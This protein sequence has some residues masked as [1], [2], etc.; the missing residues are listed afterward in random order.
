MQSTSAFAV[1]FVV[2]LNFEL[3]SA[4]GQLHAVG[5]VFAYMRPNCSPA[6]TCG[7]H[8]CLAAAP[9]D[10]DSVL[11]QDVHERMVRPGARNDWAGTPGM[12]LCRSR[13]T[14]AAAV[15]QALCVIAGRDL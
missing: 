10:S 9:M 2:R 11:L 1:V 12:C 7:A 3:L 6:R 4:A 13:A 8:S 5:A 15:L 14:A